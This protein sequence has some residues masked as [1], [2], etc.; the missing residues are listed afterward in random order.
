MNRI[1][2]FFI[3]VSVNIF[4]Q[5]KTLVDGVFAVV[6]DDVIFYSDIDEQILQYQNQ[7]LNLEDESLRNKVIE[8]L[9]YQK[10]LLHFAKQDSIIVDDTEVENS[11]SQRISFFENQLGSIEK[12]E[13]YFNKDINELTNELRPIIRNQQ[14][15]QKM[16]FEINK[17]T[18]VSP[19]DVEEFY[20]SLNKDSVPIIP[21][22]YQVA[23]ILK[24][25]DAAD[26][27]IEETLKKLND[28]RNRI[29]KGADFSTMAILY[30]EDPGSSRNG[31]LYNDI[32]KGDF[33]KEFESVVFSLDVGELS[34]I[35]KTEYGYHIAKLIDRKGNKVNVRHILMTPK[36][37]NTDM[38]KTKAFLDSIKLEI[39][40]NRID[41]ET[42]AK[43]FSTDKETRFNS[44]LL[45]N[46][47]DNSSFFSV[48]R[49]DKVLLNEISNLSIGD[50]TKPIYLKLENGKEAFRIVKLVN[51]VDE[52]VANLIDDY[53]FLSDYCLQLKQSKKLNEW[54]SKKIN[55]LFIEFTEGN[56]KYDF[57]NKLISNE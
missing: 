54:Y 2:Y 43:M 39:E 4:A 22:K 38:L 37:S 42:A 57:Y 41:F 31:G 14:L 51:L 56:E 19:R 9:F 32:K 49:I 40:S 12:I 1:F 29:S 11:I 7:G 30:S 16:Q 33:V 35:F 8:D 55:K 13:N 18:S 34:E 48:D 52:H 50:I 15:I 17:N 5:N 28:L 27:A 25:P 6:G 46:P 3:I 53:S 47:V 24:T 21:A 45:I 10:L 26:F 44:G 23:H 20:Y 36:I